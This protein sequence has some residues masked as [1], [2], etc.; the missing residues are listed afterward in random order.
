MVGAGCKDT[1]SSIRPT[2]VL[3]WFSVLDVSQHQPKPKTI[4]SNT[5]YCSLSLSL[6]RLVHYVVNYYFI[7]VMAQKICSSLYQHLILYVSGGSIYKQFRLIQ[8]NENDKSWKGKITISVEN[9]IPNN[10]RS[11]CFPYADKCRRSD[12]SALLWKDSIASMST[13]LPSYR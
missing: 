1:S 10:K 6:S 5:A 11:N 3:R 2:I 8:W 9:V 12:E 4:S 13:R 7:P